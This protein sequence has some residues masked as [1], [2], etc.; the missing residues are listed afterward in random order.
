M[1]TRIEY[2]VVDMFAEGPLTGCAL[3]VVPDSEH[4]SDAA[5][6]AVAREIGTS[7]TAFVLPAT[8]PGATHRVRVF[9][10][11]GESPFGGHS[12]VG[13][14]A[15]LVRLGRVATGRLVQ[16]CGERLLPV[17]ADVDGASLTT[18]A[19]PLEISP[20]DPAGPAEACGLR[21]E[22]VAGPA[23]TAGFG[24]AFHLLP[25]RP[26]APARAALRP[27]HP[28][29]R[30][31][32]DVLVFAWDAATRTARARMFAPGYAMPED[33]ACASAALAL[34]PWLVR[35]GLLPA[36]TGSHP[37]RL[38]QGVELHRPALLDCR[39]D[40]VGGRVT[41]ASVSGAVLPAA[42]G[43]MTLPASATTAPARP[44]P[45]PEERPC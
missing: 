2:E 1:N 10:P 17:E 23:A 19:G 38:R 6:A 16:Q 14:A 40:V 30:G 22:D 13:T 27:E 3:G 4:L 12:A 5:M 37:Y 45:T 18:T 25:V 20:F 36:T 7:E 29:W 43:R 42:K 39:V 24:P 15:T 11:G 41:G 33:P 44:A 26:D 28:V 32:P 8:A 31:Q 9:N 21:P 34:G 35:T